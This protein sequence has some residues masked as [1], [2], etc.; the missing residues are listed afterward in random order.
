MATF[1]EHCGSTRPH[2]GHSK[3]RR[4]LTLGGWVTD[5]YKCKGTKRLGHR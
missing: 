2:S 5:T 3:R 4:R 1:T